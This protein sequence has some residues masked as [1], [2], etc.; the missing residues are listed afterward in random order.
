MQYSEDESLIAAEDMSYTHDMDK[1]ESNDGVRLGY[2][3]PYLYLYV[4]SL[5]LVHAWSHQYT[6]LQC[7]T[8]QA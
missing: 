1:Q 3:Y 8:A 2:M 6:P 5:L 7:T 4:V